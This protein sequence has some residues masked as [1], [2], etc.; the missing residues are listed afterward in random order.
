MSVATRPPPADDLQA[1]RGQGGGNGGGPARRAI[2]RW[3][4]RLFRREWR[5][6]LLVLA[7]LTVAVMA[8]TLGAAVASNTVTRV[9]PTMGTANYRLTISG[10]DPSLAGDI[11]AMRQR[12]GTIEVSAHQKIVV[13]GSVATADLRDQNPKGP[14][15]Y[16]TLRLSA[17]RYPSGSDEVAVT[18][19]VAA[20]FNLHIGDVWHHGA[21]DRRVVGLVENPQNLLDKFALV[22]PGQAN[23][24]D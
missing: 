3:A 2:V 6:Q 17:G 5:Q 10:T 14:Y 19:P 13:P 11:A 24:P 12:F 20:I 23:P 22:A 1:V 16:P 7:L 9:D 21:R 4:W 18:G 15:G 8:T